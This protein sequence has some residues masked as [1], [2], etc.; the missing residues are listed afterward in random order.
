MRLSLCLAITLEPEKGISEISESS[1]IFVKIDCFGLINF[2][3]PI[4]SNK[5]LVKT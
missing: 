4:C 2:S 5:N 3:N 1:R